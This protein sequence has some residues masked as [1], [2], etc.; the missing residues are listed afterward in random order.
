M[1]S[2][3]GGEF[4][5]RLFVRFSESIDDE[6]STR[7]FSIKQT[8]S[9]AEYVSEFEELS[10]QVSGVQDHHLERIFYIGLNREMKEVI[11]IKEPQGLP[12][13]IAAV[14]K[15]EKSAFCQVVGQ[16]GGG[17]GNTSAL[18]DRDE[19]KSNKNQNNTRSWD[20]QRAEGGHTKENKPDQ[21]QGFQRP[22]LKYTDVELDA[23]RRDKVC[24]KCRAPWS[25]T[26]LCPNKELRILTVVNGKEKEVWNS[27]DEMEEDEQEEEARTLSTLSL[28]SFLGID[29]PKTTKLWGRINQA[30]VVVMLDSGASHNFISPEIV[31]KLNL[32]AQEGSNWDVL[33][34]NGVMIKAEGVCSALS[35]QLGDSDFV[36]DFLALELGSVDVILG[37]QWLEML[38]RCEVDWKIQELSFS[39]Q[40]RRVTLFGDPSLHCTKLSM[41]TL[42][43]VFSINHTSSAVV[44]AS[45][46]KSEETIEQKSF[47]ARLLDQ[48]ADVFALPSGLPPIRG[49]EH[50]I[51]LGAGVSAIS[52]PPYL[53]PHARKVVMESMVQEMLTSGIICPSVSPFSSPVLL[54]KKKD[55]SFCFCVDYRALNKATVPDK[56][57]IPVIDQLLDKLHG[58]AVFSNK[59]GGR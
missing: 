21:Q 14:L 49:Q 41:R 16:V 25:R 5:Q 18:R 48:F 9:V 24:F 30:E 32:K 46:T 36:S 47:L 43:P 29:S 42:T 27:D 33:L 55:I 57:P 7:L 31:R 17:V 56:Y 20:R 45:L 59:N 3:I 39:Y 40:G 28:N 13:F 2:W 22:R 8:G 23:M 12:N 38:G 51:T 4:K 35:F 11:R 6:P 1:V 10:A 50:A 44:L 54:V 34:G 58:A 15:M 52:V 26:H 19:K 53:Y 37:V